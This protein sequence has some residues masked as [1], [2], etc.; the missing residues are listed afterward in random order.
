MH[1]VILRDEKMYALSACAHAHMCRGT[2]SVQVEPSP[3]SG[4]D[5]HLRSDSRCFQVLTSV[6]GGVLPGPHRDWHWMSC[7]CVNMPL[8]LCTA[9]HKCLIIS[10]SVGETGMPPWKLFGHFLTK[11]IWQQR[12]MLFT[13]EAVGSFLIQTNATSSCQMSGLP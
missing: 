4:Q 11:G 9:L 6:R 1:T 2:H 13:C 5:P 3:T 12:S 8:L 10:S 7:E